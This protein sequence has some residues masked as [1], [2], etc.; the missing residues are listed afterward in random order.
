MEVENIKLKKGQALVI[1]G[2]QGVGKS[3]LAKDI[4]EQHGA[5]VVCS[6]SE[7]TS[8][9]FELGRLVD[10]K[11]DT[12]IVE[13]FERCDIAKLKKMIMSPQ[14][15]VDVRGKSPYMATMPNFILCGASVDALALENF[16]W[17]L[18]KLLSI[19]RPYNQPQCSEG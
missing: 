12:I 10:G 15:R 13:D 3:S 17:R 1:V 7:L 18:F 2:E 16:E 9:P 4:A 5:Y 14:V 11:P 19:T 8:G 6:G